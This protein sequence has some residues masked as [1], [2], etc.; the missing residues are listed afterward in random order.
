[1]SI[2]LLSDS[3]SKLGNLISIGKL[4][5]IELTELYIKAIKEEPLS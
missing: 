4:D 3:A 2:A 5:T 1:M